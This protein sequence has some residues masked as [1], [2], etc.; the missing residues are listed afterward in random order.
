ML[1]RGCPVEHNCRLQVL[2]RRFRGL[3]S[4]IGELNDC[5]LQQLNASYQDFLGY[6]IASDLIIELL[7]LIIKPFDNQTEIFRELVL[8]IKPFDIQAVRAG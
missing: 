5:S 8:I 2:S 1:C 4:F 6:L 7:V 3:K